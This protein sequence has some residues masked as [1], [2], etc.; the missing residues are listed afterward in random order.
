M[1]TY[2]IFASAVAALALTLPV[3]AGPAMEQTASAPEA[4]T[5]PGKTYHRGEV[6]PVEFGVRNW[7]DYYAYGLPAAPSGLSWVLVGNDAYLVDAETGLIDLVI[8]DLAITST[9]S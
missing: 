1:T 5:S 9:M 4:L 3:S 8:T 2:K 6:L 7:D